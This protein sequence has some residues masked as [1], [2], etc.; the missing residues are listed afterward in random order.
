M[1]P[2]SLFAGAAANS[3]WRVAP[4]PQGPRLPWDEF[5]PLAYLDFPRVGPEAWLGAHGLGADGAALEAAAAADAEPPVPERAAARGAAEGHELAQR[6][7]AEWRWVAFA[8]FF[9]DAC[10]LGRQLRALPDEDA[11]AQIADLLADTFAAKATAT[12]QRRACALRLLVRWMRGARRAILSEATLYEY[13][14][15]LRRDGAPASRAQSA[16]EAVRFAGGLLGLAL[17][18]DLVSV[19]V[20]GAAAWAAAAMRPRRQAPPLT[21]EEV[22]ALEIAAGIGE[23]LD[24]RLRAG[25]LCFVIHARSRASEAARAPGPL[26]E[27]LVFDATGAVSGGFLETAV[28][29]SKTATGRRRHLL[30]PLVAPARGVLHEDAG[31]PWGPAWV[32]AR[33]AAACDNAVGNPL[34]LGARRRDG[35]ALPMDATEVTH[36]LRRTLVD[37]GFARQVVERLTSHSCKATGL[38]WAAKAGLATTVRRPLGGHT[39]PSEVTPR[40]YSRDE[41]AAPLRALLRVYADIRAGILLPDST[42]SGMVREA[43]PRAAAPSEQDDPEPE[44]SSSSSEEEVDDT[45]DAPPGF[46]AQDRSRVKHVVGDRPELLACGRI[47]TE[48]FA[49]CFAELPV[50]RACTAALLRAAAA[51]DPDAGAAP[52]AVGGAAGDPLPQSAPDADLF[53]PPPPDAAAPGAPPAAGT[54]PP[55]PADQDEPDENID[56][57][58]ETGPSSRSRSRGAAAGP[59]PPAMRAKRAAAPKRRE[60]SRR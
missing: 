37:A 36:L 10:Q 6:R 4:R 9:G 13:V 11:G 31:P 1:A 58:I 19:R 40:A 12:L 54:P 35:V 14:S 55:A 38:S 39:K 50:C 47:L 52:A 3:G 7:A 45:E 46:V 56:D 16:I 27:D 15:S 57:G 41:L 60:R 2:R 29:K 53:E 18:A 20:R 23:S 5:D 32:A 42:R 49:P 24:L 44:S 33:A 28:R 59:T 34:M 22:A 8:E 26:L 17:P 51:G 43:T 48:A 21:V 25:F 30:L